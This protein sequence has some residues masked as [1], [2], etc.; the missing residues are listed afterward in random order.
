MPSLQSQEHPGDGLEIASVGGGEGGCNCAETLN[1]VLQI[2][3]RTHGPRIKRH[4]A[5]VSFVARALRA[6]EYAV[7]E[8]PEIQSEQGLRKPDIIAV[9]GR[10]AIV[11]DGQVVNDQIDLGSV[12]KK[13]SNK[14][15]DLEAQIKRDQKV[16]KVRFTSVTLS[17]SRKSA[18]SLV[19]LGVIR[20]DALKVLSSR[21]IIGGLPQI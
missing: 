13:K 3:H 7:L 5:I 15:K 18:E 21:T 8:E 2:C 16:D 10:T 9:L 19:G 17:W 14:Y 20:K 12:H 4:N 1:H 6:R 11:I